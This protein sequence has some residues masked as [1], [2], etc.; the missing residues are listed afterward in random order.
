MK[1]IKNIDGIIKSKKA[2]SRPPPK[3]H[4]TRLLRV[5]S[6]VKRPVKRAAAKT[7]LSPFFAVPG[8][9]RAKR[10]AAVLSSTFPEYPVG[11][12]LDLFFQ[13]IYSQKKVPVA[14]AVLGLIITFVFGM[15]SAMDA[16]HSYADIQPHVLGASTQHQFSDNK[17]GALDKLPAKVNESDGSRA[18]KIGA[19]STNQPSGNQSG[20]SG[21]LIAGAE[22]QGQNGGSVS[23]DVLFNTPIEYLQSYFKS[24]AEPDIIFRRKN[25]LQQFLSAMHSPLAQAS[26]TIAG[27]EHWKLILAIAFAESTMGKNCADNNCS[28][29]G[30]KPGA[31]SWRSYA[32]YSAWVVDFNRLLDKKYSD[33]TLEEMCGVYVKPCNPNWLA[34]TKQI[35]DSLKEQNIE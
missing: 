31:P 21:T 28:N 34:A 35:L 18:E 15:W 24:T 23:N 11:R 5:D 32:S 4:S 9:A 22:L 1:N 2:G 8:Q 25:Q 17:G 29:I 14:V 13:K 12:R 6:I 3:S 16:N 20:P 33:W 27:Q 10:V 19:G 30:V 26:E 7:A